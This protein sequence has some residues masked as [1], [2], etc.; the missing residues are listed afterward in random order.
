MK[1][2]TKCGEEKP[3]SEFYT[4]GK[5]LHSHCKDC[6]CKKSREW[7]KRNPKRRAAAE[8]KRRAKDPS[9]NEKV[10]LARFGLTPGSYQQI[11][12]CQDGVCKICGKKETAT[13]LGKTKRLAIDHDHQIGGIRGLLCSRC[14]SALGL[15][16]D[17][18]NLLQSAIKYLKFK[19][20]NIITTDFVAKCQ[21]QN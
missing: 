16:N 14:N 7:A 2:C 1:R 11:E 17:D 19:R 9:I 6:S 8:R 15:F 13:R 3:K 10:A 21:Q 18:I 4:S 5:Y 20:I 12:I